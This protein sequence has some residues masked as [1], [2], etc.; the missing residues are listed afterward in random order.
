MNTNIR[1]YK[2]YNP[3][4]DHTSYIDQSS[5][6]IGQV[7]I[8]ENCSI[9]PNVTIRGDVNKIVIKKN[10][11]IQ[12]NSVIHVT[13]K[14]Q[15]NPEGV[16]T[17][18]GENVTIGHNCTIHGS[19]ISHNVLIGMSS[20][21]LDNC[22]IKKDVIIGAGSLI[23]QNFVAE[24]GWLYYGRPV[25]KIRKLTIKEINLIQESAKNYV[26]LKNDYMT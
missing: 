10:S 3:L 11:N 15:D 16:N 17:H 8:Q 6:V 12:D 24:S 7:I 26:K 13:R 25:K 19:Q 1:K 23:S 14:S 9:W 5:V 21:L 18:I 2:D 22:I 20:V 4:V